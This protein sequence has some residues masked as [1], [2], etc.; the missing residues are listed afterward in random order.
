[1]S[2]IED[3][4]HI[5]DARIIANHEPGS[6]KWHAQRQL[7]I[8]GSEVAAILGISPWSGPHEVWLSKVDPDAVEEADALGDRIQLEVGTRLE[9][10]VLDLLAEDEGIVVEPAP[11]TVQH[12][13][14]E[15][16]AP[17]LDGVA[18]FEANSAIRN[19]EAKTTNAYAWSDWSKSGVPLYYQAQ[20]QYQLGATG[21]DAAYVPVLFGNHRF[22]WWLVERD[23]EDI[24]AI[25]EVCEEFWG[26]VERQEAPPVDGS[27]AALDYLVD[28]YGAGEDDVVVE[29]DEDAENWARQYEEAKADQK[30]AKSRKDEAKNHLIEAVGN[31]SKGVTP[32]GFKVNSVRR[33]RFSSSLAEE[34][35]AELVA[36]YSNKLDSRALRRDHPDFYEACKKP[37]SMSVRVTPPAE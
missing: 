1:M 27:S 29:L 21:L 15:W 35:D 5:G 33:S 4:T 34:K 22:E 23:D 8:G 32:S 10:L 37:S 25:A 19:V 13:S 6:P 11:V 31:A 14:Y 3:Q 18:F 9:S 2:W 17:N 28:K 7:G 26:Y 12:P 36:E 20:T 16:W 30:E 24:A